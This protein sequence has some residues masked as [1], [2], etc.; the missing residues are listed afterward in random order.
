MAPSGSLAP[1]E[2]HS[3]SGP[4]SVLDA[5]RDAYLGNSIVNSHDVRIGP[6]GLAGC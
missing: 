1:T 6:E 4:L 2:G 3:V 5:G